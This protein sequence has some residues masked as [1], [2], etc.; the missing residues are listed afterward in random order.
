MPADL[1]SLLPGWVARPYAVGLGAGPSPQQVLRR[2]SEASERH[3]PA[4]GDF[5]GCLW[6]QW[7]GGGVVLLRRPLHVVQPDRTATAL[8]ILDR[9][10]TVSPE[11]RFDGVGG[12]WLACLGY[13]DDRSWLGFY[14]QLARWRPDGT[15]T[16][17]TLG[18]AGREQATAAALDGWRTLLEASAPGP[19]PGPVDR[20]WRVGPFRTVTGAGTR[21]GYLAGVEDAVGRIHRGDFYQVNLCTRLVADCAGPPT[22]MFADLAATLQ[23]AYGALV[24]G[25]RPVLSFSPEL[26]LRVDGDEVATAPIKGT[27]ARTTE[28]TDSAM[29]RASAKDAAENIMIV[30]LMRNDLSRVSR[31]GTVVVD[32]LLALEPHPGVWHLV[33]R[34]SARLRPEAGISDLLAATFPPGSVSGAP[35]SSAVR[36]IADLEPVARGVYTGAAGFV[37]PVGRAELN[38]VI[39][40][41]ELGDGRLELGVGGGITADSVP[42][43]E[44]QECLDKAAALVSAAGSTFADH[45]AGPAEPAEV[46]L[47]S[48]GVFESILVVGSRLLRLTDHLARLDRS[49]REL[50]GVGL[51]DTV[52]DR[53]ISAVSVAPTAPSTRRVVRVTATPQPDGRLGVTVTVNPLGPRLTECALVRQPRPFLSWRHKWADRSALTAAE[54]AAAPALPYFT[55][56]SG[57]PL[58]AAGE[59]ALHSVHSVHSGHSRRSVDRAGVAETSRGNLFVLHR[60]GEW[61]TPPLDDNVLPGVTRRAVLDLFDDL[62]LGY[63][64]LPLTVGALHEAVAACWTSSL[65]GAVTVVA[66]DGS[67]I[68]AGPGAAVLAR[69]N[70]RLGFADGAAR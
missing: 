31:P 41:F 5:P 18:L 15:W 63:R 3:T 44:W 6:G 34:V 62:G 35:K 40:T 8:G 17:E 67:V 29:L 55:T 47:R 30:D 51:P 43:R 7:F 52:A 64:V 66:V 42:I 1:S 56:S 32:D 37:S 36:A 11:H 27:A 68:P 54:T 39:R 58:E 49:C 24:P 57:S 14:D 13:D 65:S 59:A 50:Y 2:L 22:A 46:D 12:G 9:Q 61:L 23:P 60:S 28:E 10:P 45:L 16:F 69:I 26:F 33:S 4:G 38:V 48:G 70:L 20:R 19:T 25:P 53:V 21:D